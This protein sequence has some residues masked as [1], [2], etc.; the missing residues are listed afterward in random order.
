MESVFPGVQIH[1]AG[2]QNYF[3]ATDRPEPKPVRRLD[4]EQVHPGLRSQA[5]QVFGNV[6][7]TAPDHGRVLTDDFNPIEFYDAQNREATR[8]SQVQRVRRM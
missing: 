7:S 6:V 4:L 1:S 5:L 2:S 8:R 3:V